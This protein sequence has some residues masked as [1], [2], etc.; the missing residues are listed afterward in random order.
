M[1]GPRRG[2]Q[3]CAM[4]FHNRRLLQHYTGW[5]GAKSCH[6]LKRTPSEGI[7][8]ADIFI[9]YTSSDRDWA[10]WIAKE[11]EALGDK[12]RVHEWEINKGGNIMAWMEERLQAANYVLLVVSE[13]YLNRPEAPYS[14]LERHAAQ[15]A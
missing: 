2:P 5:R 3:V 8:V 6:S 11:L 1:K 7:R 13:R 14:N 15:W 10:F 12:P 4:T 9:S